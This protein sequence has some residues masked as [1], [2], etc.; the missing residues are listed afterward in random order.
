MPGLLSV[1]EAIKSIGN[2]ASMAAVSVA[3]ATEELERYEASREMMGGGRSNT[4]SMNAAG[5]NTGGMGASHGY[6][7]GAGNSVMTTRG[8]SN[9]IS[10]ARRSL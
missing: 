4:S 6:G 8:V 1:A 9:A 3:K 7:G 10:I 2:A 5:P